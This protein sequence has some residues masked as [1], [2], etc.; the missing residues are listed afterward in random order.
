VI[1]WMVV[2][3]VLLAPLFVAVMFVTDE[4]DRER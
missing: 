2:V 1:S 4:R 3:A